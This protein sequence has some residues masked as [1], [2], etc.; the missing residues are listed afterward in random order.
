[1]K[2]NLPEF[3]GFESV[4][5]LIYNFQTNW[6]F[7]DPEQLKEAP[8]KARHSADEGFSDDE[9]DGERNATSRLTSEPASK[10]STA[11]PP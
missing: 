2:E 7:T 1:M 5:V 11:D 9:E 4:G 6:L 3:F 10:M 8:S